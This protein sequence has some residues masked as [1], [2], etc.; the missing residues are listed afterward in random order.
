MGTSYGIGGTHS[1]VGIV[2]LTWSLT[3]AVSNGNVAISA[4]QAARPAEANFT[5]IG[6][7]VVMGYG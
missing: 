1:L 7:A 5:P 3:L 4:V 2:S 6:V